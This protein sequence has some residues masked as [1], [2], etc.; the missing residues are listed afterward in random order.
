MHPYLLRLDRFLNIPFPSNTLIILNF[1]SY[2]LYLF[3]GNPWFKLG[4]KINS[5]SY[6]L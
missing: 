6:W 3:F 2:P 1:L 5:I 4:R